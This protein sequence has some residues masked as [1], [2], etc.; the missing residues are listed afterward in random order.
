MPNCVYTYTIEEAK[1]YWKE[2]EEGVSLEKIVRK[3]GVTYHKLR[4][5]FLLFGFPFRT[6]RQTCT[7]RYDF[8]YLTEA[9]KGYIAGIIDGEGHITSKHWGRVIVANTDKRM[10]TWLKDKL[11]CGSIGILD[12]RKRHPSWSVG[13]TYTIAAAQA[14]QLLKVIK[15]YLVIKQEACF[16]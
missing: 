7:L 14:R 16:E 3:N 10:V 1:R 11:K 4:R 9:E 6:G 15:P 12:P 2:Y 8:S 5:F 13:Y